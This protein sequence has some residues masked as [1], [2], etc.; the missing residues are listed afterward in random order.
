MLPVPDMSRIFFYMWI[1][2]SVAEALRNTPYGLP[3]RPAT[4]FLDT[5]NT[6]LLNPTSRGLGE[7]VSIPALVAGDLTARDLFLCLQ[8]EISRP[9]ILAPPL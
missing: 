3:Y 7:S 8:R 2:G 4:L 5:P 1:S 9:C 6:A